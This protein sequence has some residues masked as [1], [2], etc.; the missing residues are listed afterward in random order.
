MSNIIGK[1]YSVSYYVH[2]TL[3]Y[4]LVDYLEFIEIIGFVN[5]VHAMLLDPNTTFYFRVLDMLLLEIN[6]AVTVHGREYATI[7]NI[8]VV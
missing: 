8:A 4:K 7:C 6:I 2:L 3:N 1:H 5:Y